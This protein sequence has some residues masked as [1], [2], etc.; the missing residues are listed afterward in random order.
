MCIVPV[1]GKS[2]KPKG[3]TIL[4]WPDKKPTSIRDRSGSRDLSVVGNCSGLH[5]RFAAR[6]IP[7]APQRLTENDMTSLG[8]GTLRWGLMLLLPTWLATQAH[9][10]DA[11]PPPPS[12]GATAAAAP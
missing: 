2:Q 6:S 11:P 1:V 4:A 12:A 5:Q 10:A 9:A 8:I 7:I 3:L